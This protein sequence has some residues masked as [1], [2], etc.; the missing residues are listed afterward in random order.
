M[1]NFQREHL[2]TEIRRRF[3]AGDM[4]GAASLAMKGYGPEIYGFLAA[5]HR[6]QE[7]ADEVFSL[8]A[9]GL[10]RGLPGFSWQSSLRTWAYA[11]ARRLSLRYRRDARRHAQRVAPLPDDSALAALAADVRSATLPYL[12]SQVK[13]RISELRASLP[14]EDQELLLLRVDRKLAWAELAQVLRGE[15]AP[16]LEGEALKREA[17]RLRK[18]F[19]LIKDQLRELGRREGLLDDPDGR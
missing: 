11:V 1:E 15:D 17:A 12:Q 4:E 6:R 16:P 10:W 3:D 14:P 18:R 13:D 5:T 19:Q 7:D 8:F 2:E 9:E